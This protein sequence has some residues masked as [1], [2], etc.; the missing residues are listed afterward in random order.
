M[1][2]TLRS[3]SSPATEALPPAVGQTALVVEDEEPLAVLLTRFLQRMG[4]RVIYARDGNQAR[5]MVA[6][7]GVEIALV[8][9]DCGLPD[10]SGAELGAEIR[11]MIPAMPLVLTSGRDQT[12]QAGKFAAAGPAGFLAKPFRPVEVEHCVG[13]L[14]ARAA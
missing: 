2:S 9:V 11:A 14:F 6:E 5:R 7:R 3:E 13:E 12:A 1:F 4:W 10:I 8:L